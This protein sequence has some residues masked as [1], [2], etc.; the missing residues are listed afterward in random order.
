[1]E[2]VWY[3][4]FIHTVATNV[5]I[6]GLYQLA[7]WLNDPD[8]DRAVK[9]AFHRIKEMKQETSVS[10]WYIYMSMSFAG[11]LLTLFMEVDSKFYQNMMPIL[12]TVLWDQLW[13][14]ALYSWYDISMMDWQRFRIYNFR[15]ISEYIIR[16]TNYYKRQMMINDLTNDKEAKYIERFDNPLRYGDN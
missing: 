16:Y 11:L 15:L 12:V 3:T 7:F 8:R 13:V 14:F 1:M 4:L 9:Y 5:V 2:S 6:N 10:S